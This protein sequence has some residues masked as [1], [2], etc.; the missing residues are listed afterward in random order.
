MLKWES[1]DEIHEG[2]RRLTEEMRRLREELTNSASSRYR[3]AA[4]VSLPTEDERKL[5]SLARD[6]P[7]KS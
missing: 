4:S 3:R 6:D 1:E 5:R 7:P 2:L